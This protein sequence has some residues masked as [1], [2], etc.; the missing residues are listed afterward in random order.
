M[1]RKCEC[2]HSGR[3]AAPII[4][5]LEPRI[6]LSADLPG[7]DVPDADPNFV[8][9]ADID[10]ILAQAKEAFLSQQQAAEDQAAL[11]QIEPQ[12]A[13]TPDVA[14]ATH[15]PEQPLRQ[16]LVIVD[17]SVPDH[18]TLLLDM[19]PAG[20]DSAEL[21]IVFLDS[22]RG[23]I[24]QIS[25][26]LSTRSDLDAIHL[27]THG[28]DASIQLGADALDLALL[29]N[30]PSVISGW[31][32]ALTAEG[33][34]LIYGCNVAETEAGRDLI[35]TLAEMTRADIAAS[36]DLTGHHGLGGDWDLEY[37]AGQIEA[38]VTVS[39]STQQSWNATLAAPSLS[40]ANDLAGIN[41]DP[42]T[43]TGTLVST[44]I[45]GHVTD[46]DGPSSGIAVV[47]V[48]DTNGTWEYTTDS[49]SNWY[50]FGTVDTST[51]RLLAADA[52]TSVRFVPD[53][54]WNGTVSNGI[55][56]HAWDQS[57]GTIGGT[58]DISSIE[59]VRDEFIA[60]SF[61]GNDGTVNWTGDWQELGESDGSA[62]GNVK[63][64]TTPT[65]LEIG[66]LN[67]SITGDG[68]QRQ[69]DLS[70]ATSATLTLDIW[71]SGLPKGATSVTLA[72]SSD[73]I[74][75]TDL[76]TFDYTSTP[77]SATA[78][79]YDISAYASST[80]WVRL[81]GSG[82]FNNPNFSSH[83]FFDD[84]QIEYDSTGGG[85]SAFSA[86]SASSGITVNSVD[87]AVVI[88]GDTS[89]SGNE[90]TV[91]SG[92]LIATDDADGVTDGT[93]FSVSADGASGTASIDPDT[94]LWAYTPNADFN[95][96]DSFTVTVTDDD[97][98]TDTQVINVTVTPVV[99]TLTGGVDAGAVTDTTVH[100]MEA[101]EPPPVHEAPAEP[102]AE[103]ERIEETAEPEAEATEETAEPEPL[104]G[105]PPTPNTLL[106]G[107]LEP[108]EIYL[109]VIR[110]TYTER[111]GV[112]N[113]PPS[114]EKPTPDSTRTFQ[115]E[116]KS[117]WK[118]DST[119]ASLEMSD[120]GV[121]QE[122]WNDLDQMAQEM[123]NSIDELEKR[124]RLSAEAAAGFGISL[125]AGFVSWALRT[126]TMAASFLA[127]MPT[128]RH[129]DPMPVLA[130]DGKRSQANLSQVDE[131]PEDDEQEQ[132]LADLLEKE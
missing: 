130:E 29:Q 4:E 123:E 15:E 126:G 90:G 83:M 115:Q 22:Q 77:T 54:D 60:N 131:V 47:G 16:E 19:Q 38:A 118:A 36:N 107:P 62:A 10:R 79:S 100:S 65:A 7:L 85:Q 132:A 112:K 21:R 119:K 13:D 39:G 57:S 2:K 114:I 93:V 26:I 30:N 20:G 55:T 127:T 124:M 86:E 68:A 41:E 74:N 81:I 89:G 84:V 106:T 48:D 116:L 129:V 45:A 111:S 108:D 34:I 88:G 53:S 64:D 3:H 52:G 128:W 70:G 51:A 72:V 27:I 125:T 76:Q 78:Y 17:P 18:E 113:S 46:A 82:S 31:G 8:S 25:Q 98:Y 120:L 87:D 1:K 97:G 11:Q 66:G 14:L 44:L 122:L 32:G 42:I 104:A 92:T 91:I 56:F 80:T 95:G 73:G 24:E 101:P 61:T 96:T 58:A 33:D 121:S 94:G 43:N 35:D 69:A 37:Q 50:A 6:L 102:K 23:G 109:S 63:A 59:T 49:G 40:G 67:V 12:Q 117:F 5:S 103:V 28:A 105:L 110:D 9:D 99:N 75:W 71:R